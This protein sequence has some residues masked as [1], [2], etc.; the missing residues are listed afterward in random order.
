MNPNLFV[1]V[2]RTLK[3]KKNPKNQKKKNLV[4][5][6]RLRFISTHKPWIFKVL[7]ARISVVMVHTGFSRMAFLIA[8]VA[9][10][11]LRVCAV[12]SLLWILKQSPITKTKGRSPIPHLITPTRSRTYKF[13]ALFQL[14]SSSLTIVL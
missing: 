14:K 3:K 13:N 2:H 11:R 4:G 9:C 6:Q 12:A 7:E 10:S 5:L 8:P 1:A